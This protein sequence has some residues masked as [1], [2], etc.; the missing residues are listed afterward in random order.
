[1]EEDIEKLVNKFNGG[2]GQGRRINSFIS[3]RRAG[4]EKNT[5]KKS[6]G[7]APA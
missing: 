6:S 3:L 2:G 5:V 1:M 7:T 4:V